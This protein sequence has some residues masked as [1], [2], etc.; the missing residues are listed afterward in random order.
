MGEFETIMRFSKEA[1]MADEKKAEETKDKPEGAPKLDPAAAAKAREAAEAA[2]AKLAGMGQL[3][4]EQK[5]A[6]EAAKAKMAAKKA[7]EKA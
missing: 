2:K 5:K 4:D 1:T 3:T 6:L 7:E